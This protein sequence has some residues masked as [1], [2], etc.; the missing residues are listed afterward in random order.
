MKG[1]DV[2]IPVHKYD[3]T[4]EVLLTR[5]L[6]SVKEMAVFSKNE[7]IVTDLIVV[8]P[9]LPTDKI[10][11][12]VEW[13]DEFSSFNVVDNS[14]ETDFCSQVNFAVAEAA[15]NDYFMV[16]EFDDMVTP[17][18]LTM[19]APYVEKRKK[20][21]VFLPLVEL[22][23]INDSTAPNGYVNEI[24]WSSSFVQNELGLLDVE[25]LKEYCNFNLTGALIRKNDFV[26]AG[27]L[28]PSIK[29]SFNYELLLR[30]A[31]LYGEVF[32]IPKVGYYHFIGRMDSLTHSYHSTMSQ[33]EGAW[34]ITLAGQEYLFK[35]D[36]KKEYSPENK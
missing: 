28:K 7:N 11:S 26:K 33:K 31:N 1:V 8:G 17:K 22:Y 4:V 9:S 34:W 25:A 19:A 14:G 15:K 27:C 3:E 6:S 10:M 21:S 24:A 32:V 16:V 23:D 30:M 36:R 2:I 12:L 5:C 18:W 35:K 13:T 20:V 29:L